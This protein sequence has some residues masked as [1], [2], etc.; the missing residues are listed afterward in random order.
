MVLHDAVNAD[1]VRNLYDLYEDDPATVDPEPVPLRSSTTLLLPHLARLSVHELHLIVFILIFLLLHLYYRQLSILPRTSAL[2]ERANPLQKAVM[3]KCFEVLPKK[4]T[5]ED[6]ENEREERQKRR[7]QHSKLR[8]ATRKARGVLNRAVKQR[9][10]RLAVIGKPVKASPADKAFIDY[11]IEN[12]IPVKYLRPNQKRYGSK[13]YDRYQRYMLAANMREAAQLGSSRAD[14]IHDHERGWLFYPKHESTQPGHIVHATLLARGVGTTTIH[15]DMGLNDDCL[16]L[17]E[18]FQCL[19]EL[20]LQMEN[21]PNPPDS[22]ELPQN[23]WRTLKNPVSSS[24]TAKA[25]SESFQ[26][27]KESRSHEQ[28]RRYSECCSIFCTRKQFPKTA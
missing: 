18:V 27:P 23:S 12:N 1:G 14:F 7:A 5:R 24:S 13:S 25:S 26:C 15:E 20:K 2:G 16:L 19:T 28:R 4:L 22:G 17:G 3:R 9:P 21:L 10:V 6:A 11:A 8:E